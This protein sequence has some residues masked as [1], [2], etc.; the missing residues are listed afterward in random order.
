MS[1]A[2]TLPLQAIIKD[3]LEITESIGIDENVSAADSL[4]CFNIFQNILKELPLHGLSWPKMTVAPVAL[5]WNSLTPNTV[6]MPVDYF[7]VP[8]VSFVQNSI[9]VDLQVITKQ[10]YDEIEKPGT[11]A[12]TPKKIYI[13]PN[14][15]GF[16]WPA[17]SADPGLSLTYQ[18]IVMDAT[19]T[20]TPDVLQCWIGGMGLW[21]AWE[22]SP[23]FSVPLDRR[24]D[25]ERRFLSRQALM[26]GYATE[27][28][29]ICIQVQE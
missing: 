17:P 3:A 4:A 21:L 20:A 12:L 28:A 18:A 13:A 6:T 22:M 14:N 15:Q 29:P 19:R 2:W 9:N 10:A 11:V 16:L 1:T 25:I 23:K 26:L 24:A 8:T 27:T 5:A 7:G